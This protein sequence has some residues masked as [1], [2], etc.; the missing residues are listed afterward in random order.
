MIVLLLAPE[1]FWPLRRLGA[2]FHAAAEGTAAFESA[3]ALLDTPPAPDCPALPASGP[4]PVTVRRL[5]VTWPDRAAPALERIDADFPAP[6][7]T[8]V[9]GPSGCGKS[10][11][12]ATLLGELSRGNGAVR[13]GSILVGDDDL[14][15]ADPAS[16]QR[17]VAWL[18][19]RPWLVAGSLADNVRVGRPDAADADVWSAL[20]Q[21]GIGELVAASPD[22][23]DTVLGED[24]SGWSAGQ[25]AR[26]VLA[27]VLLADRPF[28]LLDEPTA[29]LDAETEAVLLE[30]LRRLARRATVIVVAH[31]EAVVAAADHEVRLPAPAPAP[32]PEHTEVPTPD[33]RRTDEP[34]PDV[35]DPTSRWGLRTGILLGALSAAAGVALTTTAAWLITRASEH[36]PVLYL[37]VAI[38]GVRLFGLARPTLRYAERL[39]SHDAA[40][41]LLAERRAAVYDALVPLVPGR[42]GRRRGDVLASVV[43][44]VD[45][46]VDAQLRVR[47]PAWTA[48]LGRQRGSAAGRAALARRGR[49]RARHH[50]GRRRRRA[51]RAPWRTCR[52]TGLRGRPGGAGGR[53]RGVHRRACARWRCGSASPTRSPWST[54]PAVASPQRA[55]ARCGLWPAGGCWSGSVAGWVWSRSRQRCR[56]AASPLRSWP[57]SC[58]CPWP[59]R[60]P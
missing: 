50:P 31:R 3:T 15:T 37:M 7:L 21:V 34:A 29:H 40:L 4:R 60:T 51:A 2:E 36:P 12:L 30:T 45:A 35:A 59:C 25:R 8:A 41:R 5:T 11:L 43:D 27:R 33:R 6:G 38:V 19:Q 26:L 58:S 22:G 42:L 54:R 18:P 49:R 46:L 17:Q 47:Q 24:G 55:P 20:E 44:D 23:I 9:T 28:V 16:W 39:V 56:P 52:R 1:A 53:G 32:A 13:D 14:L 10:T 57:C 48:L